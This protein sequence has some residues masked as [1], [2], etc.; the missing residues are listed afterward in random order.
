MFCLPKDDE[1]GVATLSSVALFSQWPLKD[2]LGVW[3]DVYYVCLFVYTP[4]DVKVCVCVKTELPELQHHKHNFLF[5]PTC[6]QHIASKNAAPSILLQ[7]ITK[8]LSFLCLLGKLTRTG[9]YAGVVGRGLVVG[10]VKL[11]IWRCCCRA[12]LLLLCTLALIFNSWMRTTTG[13]FCLALPAS[14]H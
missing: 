10:T 2:L 12:Q 1:L 4:Q 13:V 7:I 9:G 3:K 11:L 8:S 6:S 5:M 14:F